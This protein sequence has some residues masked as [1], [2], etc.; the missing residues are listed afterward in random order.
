[1]KKLKHAIGWAGLVLGLILALGPGVTAALADGEVKVPA[2]PQHLMDYDLFLGELR[3]AGALKFYETTEEILRLGQFERALLR[4]SFLKSAVSGQALYRG[5]VASIDLRLRF[6]REQMHLTAPEITP[7][8]P[9]KKRKVRRQVAKAPPP[10]AETKPPETPEKGK[11]EGAPPAAGPP[12]PVTPTAPGVTPG[13]PP[14]AAPAAPPKAPEAQA[15]PEGEEAAK[16]KEEK[17]AKPAPPPSLWQRIKNR[18]YFWKKKEKTPEKAK[19][20]SE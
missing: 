6:L 17:E 2:K 15:A 12:V 8:K 19:E 4:Y 14:E 9:P 16:V 7:V 5:L 13:K 18:I 3:S 20:K 11:E 10:P 1:M